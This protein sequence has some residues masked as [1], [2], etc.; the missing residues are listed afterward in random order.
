MRGSR[1]FCQWG[2]TFSYV[3]VCGGGGGVED[4]NNTKSGPLS[5]RQRLSADD[6]P[7]LNAGFVAL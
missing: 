6:G 4:P 5:A 3:C 1:N 2:P 7:I